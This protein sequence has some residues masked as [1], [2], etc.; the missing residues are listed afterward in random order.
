LRDN[1]TVPPPDMD[2]VQPVLDHIRTI[3]TGVTDEEAAKSSQK[4]AEQQDK[5]TY[6]VEWLAAGLQRR[7]KLGTM[8]VFYGGVNG[9]KDVIFE[10]IFG[11]IYNFDF[12]TWDTQAPAFHRYYLSMEPSQTNYIERNALLCLVKSFHFQEH[13]EELHSLLTKETR[14]ITSFVHPPFDIVDR[15]NC[16]LSLEE[17]TFFENKTTNPAHIVFRISCTFVGPKTEKSFLYFAYVLGNRRKGTWA[18]DDEIREVAKNVYFYLM[19]Y[20]VSLSKST[21]EEEFPETSGGDVVLEAVG[22][23]FEG[24]RVLLDGGLDDGEVVSEAVG[25][26]LETLAVVFDGEDDDFSIIS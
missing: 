25:G 22:G 19:R 24:T 11:R 7:Q 14:T 18:T 23:V 6:I 2:L 26:I 16:I 21:R 4:K 15:R 5:S 20:R 1:L 17:R 3:L 9:G 12:H 8:L 10:E 13:E